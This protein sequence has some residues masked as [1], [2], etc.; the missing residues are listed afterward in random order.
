MRRVGSLP[1]IARQESA[2]AKSPAAFRPRS[3]LPAM[4]ASD[5]REGAERRATTH[6]VV[7]SAIR[8]PGAPRAASSLPADGSRRSWLSRPRNAP[9]TKPWDRR[10]P[11][12]RPAFGAGCVRDAATRPYARSG[13]PGRNA[14]RSSWLTRAA[15]RPSRG[16]AEPGGLAGANHPGRELPAIPAAGA[17][18]S[19][20]DRPVPI[21]PSVT[22]KG[23]GRRTQA[24]GSVKDYI[25]SPPMPLV[26]GKRYLR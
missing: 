24:R 25:P 14:G 2:R 13:A 16:A 11:E 10:L 19:P 20:H 21:M 8:S 12:P 3:L 22:G 1:R 26:V 6:A 18:P 15:S 5:M 23:D 7:S 9:R 17:A 4:S